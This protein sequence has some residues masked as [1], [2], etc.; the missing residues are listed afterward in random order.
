MADENK[1]LPNTEP[2]DEESELGG[3]MS[4]LEHLEELRTRLVRG[5]IVLSVGTLI[6]FLYSDSLIAILRQPLVSSSNF[7]SLRPYMGLGS[8]NESTNEV[9]PS[10]TTTEN[11]SEGPAELVA[12]Y[13]LEVF[14]VKMKVSIVAALFVFFPYIFYEVWMFISPGLYKREK[15]FLLPAIFSSWFCFVAGGLFAYFLMLPVMIYFFSSLAESAG[16]LNYWS[17]DFYFDNAIHLV[18]AFGVVFEEPIV[19]A[20]LAKLDLVSVQGMKNMRSYVWVGMFILGAIVTPPDPISQT[21][22]AIPLILLYEFS[23]FLI[24]FFKPK[25]DEPAEASA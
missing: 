11:K 10:T 17:L 19:I 4:F 25:P 5:L 18:L 14:K 23:I 21:M 8:S 9:N 24:P 2:Y 20:L 1:A 3:H 16:V 13:P 12:L 15:R 7:E 6:L 22:C